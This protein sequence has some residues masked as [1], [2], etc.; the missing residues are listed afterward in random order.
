MYAQ[1]ICALYFDEES[2]Y[3][4]SKLYLKKNFECTHGKRIMSRIHGQAQSNM[5]LSW[6]HKQQS[7]NLGAKSIDKQIDLGQRHSS[8]AA[9]IALLKNRKK[10][11]MEGSPV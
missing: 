4:I 9:R 3:E 10:T 2:I 8:T 6:G 7:I 5:P 1:K 11:F